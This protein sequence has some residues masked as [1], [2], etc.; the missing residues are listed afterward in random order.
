MEENFIRPRGNTKP[1]QVHALADF[2]YRV[3]VHL[4]AL[5]IL[6]Q[7]HHTEDEYRQAYEQAL[8]RFPSAAIFPEPENREYLRELVHS[9]TKPQEKSD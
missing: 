4:E 1:D 7:K 9:G 8:Q 6:V 2:M 3:A 5:E